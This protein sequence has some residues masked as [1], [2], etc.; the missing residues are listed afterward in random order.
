MK[1]FIIYVSQTFYFVLKR[2][3]CICFYISLIV[4]SFSQDANEDK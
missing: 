4:A 2:R 3:G 1:I